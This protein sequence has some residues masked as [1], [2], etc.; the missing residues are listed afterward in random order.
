M[1]DHNVGIYSM[2]VRGLGNTFK[3]NQVFLWLKNHPGSIF[4]LQETHSTVD[5]EKKWADEWG[6]K[7]FFS[8]GSSNSKG[9]CILFNNADFETIKH[10]NDN[11][12]RILILDI[13][14]HGQKVTLA[15]VYGFNYDNPNFFQNV[16]Q[17]LQDFECE[18]IIIGGGGTLI[19]F[20]II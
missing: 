10:F 20:L 2:N 8:H 4:L 9:V 6:D 13:I 11:D 7:I 17:N 12:G 5:S 19:L 16:E 1:N 3:R 15:N 14:L 18:S